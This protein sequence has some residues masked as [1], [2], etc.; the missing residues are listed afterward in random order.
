[1]NTISG[2]AK[3]KNFR[4]LFYSGRISTVVMG[5]LV[6]KVSPKKEAVLQWHT[7]AGNNNT[8]IKVEVKFTLPKVSVKIV[9]TWKCHVD[10]STKGRY[11]MILGKYVL[12]KL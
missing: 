9:V 2:K 8:N 6:E 4:I 12:T 3:F 5:R 7:Q 10:E 1:M 11:D